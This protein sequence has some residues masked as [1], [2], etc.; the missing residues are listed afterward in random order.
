M[1]GVGHWN[2]SPESWK[3]L[4]SRLA[5]VPQL[6]G[7]LELPSP[8]KGEKVLGV[9]PS[10]ATAQIL[11][12]TP[13]LC[14]LL[15]W[16]SKDGCET[17]AAALRLSPSVR[18][19]TRLQVPAPSHQ[20]C[21]QQRA[22]L[23]Q[24]QKETC[25]APPAT[26]TPQLWDAYTWGWQTFLR[27]ISWA[28]QRKLPFLPSFPRSWLRG[29]PSPCAPPEAGCSPAHPAHPTSAAAAAPA[30]SRHWIPVL[31]WKSQAHQPGLLHQPVERL[32][33]VHGCEVA[34]LL[35]AHGRTLPI[36]FPRQMRELP[37]Q[38]PLQGW[39]GHGCTPT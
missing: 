17:S 13:L 6:Q 14:L 12:G 28:I 26:A 8:W 35:I 25:L 30:A 20:F 1:S 15:H 5:G 24:V 19:R 33:R 27:G 7:S 39:G 32:L 29:A 38:P 16:G 4:T 34:F 36:L 10:L 2:S 21:P 31:P 3:R 9:L 37:V 23:N 22:G 18:L 11:S